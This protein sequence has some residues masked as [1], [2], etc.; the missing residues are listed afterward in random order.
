[1]QRLDEEESEG[2]AS[3]L[4]GAGGE[5]AVSEQMSLIGS[6]VLR[7][8]QVGTLPEIRREVLD[9]VDIAAYGI[10]GV[11]TT[12]WRRRSNLYVNRA[13]MFSCRS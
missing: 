1:M 2:R 10:L 5:L 3:L 13:L 12:G 6:D 11:I 9:G 7:P 4:D 8:K